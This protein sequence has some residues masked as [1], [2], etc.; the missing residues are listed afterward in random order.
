MDCLTCGLPIQP[1]TAFA[2]NE[3]FHSV[4]AEDN[5]LTIAERKAEVEKINSKETI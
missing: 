5:G 4:C 1:G 2:H 3:Y